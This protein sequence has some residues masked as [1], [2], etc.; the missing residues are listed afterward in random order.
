MARF[1]RW[2]EKKEVLEE[3]LSALR[4][5]QV[6]AIPTETF[7]GLAVDPRN[8]AALKR[9]FHVKHRPPEKPVLLL[10]GSEK[11]L[12]SWVSFVPP[13]ARRLMKRF[14]PGPLTLV[15]PAKEGLPFLL[16]AHTGKIAV[17]QSPHPVVRAITQRFGPV[18]GTSANLSGAPPARRAEEV[19]QNLPEV[20]LIV[21]AGET[22]GKSPSTILDVSQDPPRLLRE[23]EISLAELERVLREEDA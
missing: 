4:E 3:I 16:T 9:L 10:I 13:L 7:Y 22:Q 15:L 6:V 19:W 20:D 14:W 2:Q 11:D 23:G 8:E 1:L 5:G 18:T 12:A 17:R 21:D